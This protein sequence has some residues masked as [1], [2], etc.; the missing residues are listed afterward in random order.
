MQASD[1]GLPRHRSLADMQTI[2]SEY[3]LTNYNAGTNLQKCF[4]DSGTNRMDWA[5]IQTAGLDL[6]DPDSFEAAQLNTHF[7]ENSF[8]LTYMSRPDASADKFYSTGGLR[9]DIGADEFMSG[10]AWTSRIHEVVTASIS[11]LL[12]KKLFESMFA[13]RP[14]IFTG[15]SDYKR[16]QI[17]Q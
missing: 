14:S 16:W 1:M 10:R 3:T 7:V 11:K 15:H 5:A 9:I 13:A 4:F 12:V 2:C 8:Y 6:T 17:E